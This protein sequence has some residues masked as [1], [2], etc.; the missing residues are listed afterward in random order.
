MSDL[1]SL[2]SQVSSLQ[3]Q[4]SSLNSQIVGLKTTGNISSMVSDDLKAVVQNNQNTVTSLSNSLSATYAPIT[5]S[6]VYAPITGSAVY[7]P[8]ATVAAAPTAATASTA[9]G[10]IIVTSGGAV[11]I[12]TAV[13]ATGGWKQVTVSAVV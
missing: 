8:K 12:S 1:Q 6:A 2:Q 4:V 5:G 7:A 13:A 3:S 9:I 10:S 11:Y